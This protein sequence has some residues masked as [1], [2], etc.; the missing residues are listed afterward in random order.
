VDIRATK[1]NGK[2][3]R[4]IAKEL[5]LHRST[6]KKHLAR[7]DYPAYRKD[8]WKGSLLAPYAQTIKDFLEADSYQATCGFWTRSETATTS[9]AMTP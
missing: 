2:S 6:V 3:I 7:D 8:K 5:G 9:A 1:R 4:A